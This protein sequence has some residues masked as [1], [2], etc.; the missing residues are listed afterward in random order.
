[1]YE[2]ME[3]DIQGDNIVY[4]TTNDPD[5]EYYPP[6]PHNNHI[7]HNVN[8]SEHIQHYNNTEIYENKYYQ[9]EIVLG[10]IFTAF[11]S[12][13]LIKFYNIIKNNVYNRRRRTFNRINI[14]SLNTIILCEQLSD[15]I[16]SVC[17]DEFKDGD[18]IKKLNCNHIFHKDCLEPWLNN[19]RNCPLCRQNIV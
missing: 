18:T 7:H 11:T 17:L 15:N 14:D 16:C 3:Y 13:Q 8:P 2:S 12:I 6:S 5:P 19:N 9:L 10:F 1:M 4:L